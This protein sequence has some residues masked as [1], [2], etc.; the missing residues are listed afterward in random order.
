[1]DSPNI[2]SSSS[3]SLAVTDRISISD[4]S[5]LNINYIFGRIEFSIIKK[6]SYGNNSVFN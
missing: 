3:E 6:L 1:M 2:F 4:I 5:S